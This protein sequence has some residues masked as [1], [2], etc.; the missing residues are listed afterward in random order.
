MVSVKLYEQ[1][2]ASGSLYIINQNRYHIM[3]FQ[4]VRPLSQN[5]RVRRSKIIHFTAKNHLLLFNFATLY[6]FIINILSKQV[7]SDCRILMP[8][9]LCN[10]I[11]GPPCIFIHNKNNLF[12][13]K[14]HHNIPAKLIGAF[15]SDLL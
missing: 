4:T 2:G 5:F 10:I 7:A 3:T 13:I 12:S 1:R 6:F 11:Y 14:E 9:S 8:I 15:S